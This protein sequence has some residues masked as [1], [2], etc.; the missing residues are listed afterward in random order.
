M[1]VPQPEPWLR[2]THVDLPVPQRAVIHALEQA[3]EDIFFWCSQLSHDELEASYG[4]IPSVAFHMRHISRS[5]D[6]LWTYACGQDIW[7]YQFELL[8]AEQEPS[9]QSEQV[10][11]E[12]EDAIATAIERV[13]ST[14]IASLETPCG[15]GRDKIPT[16][17]G[18]LLIHMAEHTQRH[19]GQAITTAKIALLQRE[20]RLS[21]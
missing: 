13:H 20:K 21:L 11:A 3:K 18:A 14:D 17:R 2:R 7:M 1:P 4:T 16:T 8:T 5:L 6:R 15:V 9:Q 10:F 19:V 12:L